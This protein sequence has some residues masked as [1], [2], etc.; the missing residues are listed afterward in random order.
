MDPNSSD[1]NKSRESP[2][3]NVSLVKPVYVN[4]NTINRQ[5]RRRNPPDP[6]PAEL[7]AYERPP[8]LPSRKFSSVS[9][10]LDT[11]PKPPPR[12]HS[13]NHGTPPRPAR[14]HTVSAGP[15]LRPKQ[16]DAPT[17]PILPRRFGFTT[18]E[19]SEWSNP[20][21]FDRA[22]DEV[23]FLMPNGIII[24]L[25]VAINS[26]LMEIKMEL[27]EKAREYPLFW[28]LRDD[29]SYHFACVGPQGET[30]ELMDEGKWY[31]DIAPIVPI[32]K[33]IERKSFEP[34]RHLSSQIGML[35]GKALHEFDA[36]K[37]SEVN[38]F[39]WTMKSLVD[40]EVEKR[41][42]LSW[43]QKMH[44]L[45]PSRIAKSEEL[46]KFLQE[47]LNKDTV[48]ISL[49]LDLSEEKKQMDYLYLS[50]I[51]KSEELAKFLQE[52][53]KLNKDTESMSSNLDSSE[54]KPILLEVSPQK[55]P[56]ELLAMYF[57]K[58][59]ENEGSDWTALKELKLKA[60]GREE[61]LMADVP[62]SQFTYIREHISQEKSPIPLVI[63]P[64]DSLE[65]PSD[66]T[67]EDLSN[68]F[69]N[70]RSSF[71]SMTATKMSFM[72][73]WNIKEEFSFRVGSLSKLDTDSDDQVEVQVEAG[74]YHGGASLCSETQITREVEFV[75]GQA[76]IDQDLNFN[77]E[78]C[79]IPRNARLCLAIY[80]VVPLS[81]KAVKGK[82][83]NANAGQEKQKTRIPIAWVNTTV[84]DYRNQLKSGS[85]S[86]YS[87]AYMD[88]TGETDLP[89]ALGSVVNNHDHDHAVT[90]TISFKKYHPT[91]SVLFPSKDEM[92]GRAKENLTEEEDEQSDNYANIEEV[93][94]VQQVA[95][96]DLMTELHEQEKKS[97]WSLRWH[98]QREIP[99]VL[100]KL[101]QVVEWNDHLQ[102]C[103]IIWLISEWPKLPPE[104]ALELLDYAYADPA[105]RSFA[106]E[107][108]SDLSDDDLLLYLLQLV[109]ALKHEN[110]LKCEL[111]EFLIIR[112]L[113]NKRIGHFLFWHLRSEMY[114]PSVSIRFGLL[115]ETYCRGSGEH[116]KQLI[117]QLDSLKKLK[118][119]KKEVIDPGCSR[120][121]KLAALQK[122]LASAPGQQTFSD[123]LN[124]LEPVY[125]ISQPRDKRWTFK[126]SKMAPLWLVF[127]NKYAP[128]EDI[129]LIF[130]SGDDLRQD[131]LTLQII[132]I[133]D[134]I[135][136]D[137]GLDL[138][139]NPYGCMSTDDR[140][141]LIEVVLNAETIAKIQMEK[142]LFTA[143]CAFKKG[144]LLAWLR[145]HN[146]S[147]EALN[148]AIHEFTLSCA[149]YCVATY[150]L[151]IADRHSDNIMIMKTGQLF[152]IDFGHIL[153]HFKEKFGIKRE[154]QPF[155]LTHDFIHIIT[156][157]HHTKSDEFILFKEYCERAFLILRRY[158]SFIISLF[159]MMISTGLP[160]LQ[161]EKD[162]NYLRETLKLDMTEEAA[163]QHFRDKFAE[164]LS[165]SWK[166]SINWAF[167]VMAK[168]TK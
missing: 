130:K 43:D 54:E 70:P 75:D 67:Y 36:L 93:Q 3:C 7:T 60:P 28:C 42:Q 76:I 129:Y 87:W 69:R 160:E 106:I 138:R 71:S 15:L 161:S 156:K 163:L 144:S 165:N 10:D 6:P 148:K 115:L 38:D 52:R 143:T 68:I 49:H 136:K 19:A 40:N 97:L 107:C 150:V 118:E 128:K 108:I 94:Q 39:R 79:N 11:R 90:L 159:A 116:V 8:E 21:A 89:Y 62:L 104:Q 72:S 1:D 84:Y 12:R 24:Q 16:Y 132:R 126:E 168:V 147:E 125:H 105:V 135:W 146:S 51:T 85:M 121:R 103:E 17:T 117:K 22:K 88:H 47:R 50:R 111:G 53:L 58:D 167:H 82:P 137:N 131:M 56:K 114:V 92:I 164:A 33:V 119:L 81:N 127:E 23:D 30:L 61:Y 139:M 25:K 5:T 145:D 162:L 151:G 41:N 45:Y 83:T 78:V 66:N 140:E 157:G 123:F 46:P 34:Q 4:I 64:N 120:E 29:A 86:L 142:G 96:R 98:C 37:N 124:P 18:P 55:K 31:H 80:K 110:Y 73:S 26:T 20:F 48:S 95:D 109:Q 122:Y 155:V 14:R 2:Y 153:G 99:H 152:H 63:V 32:L 154:R 59:E 112:A 158:G 57:T 35:I 102:V 74:L 133:M 113:N 44:Y 77:I 100:P 13:C 141:G 91:F 101:L 9:V 134:K 149:G 166:T 27:W 65:V